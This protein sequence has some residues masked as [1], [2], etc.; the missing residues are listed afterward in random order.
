MVITRRSNESLALKKKHLEE[1]LRTKKSAEPKD[2]NQTTKLQN[3]GIC[4]HLYRDD[5]GAVNAGGIHKVF[6]MKPV[7][8]FQAKSYYPQILN[9]NQKLHGIPLSVLTKH[10]I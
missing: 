10:N 6:V 5:N 2:E 3:T 8:Y 7:H 9:A 4:M 1:L